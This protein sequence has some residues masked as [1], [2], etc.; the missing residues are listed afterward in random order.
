MPYAYL[1]AGI[2][3]HCPVLIQHGEEAP[4][5]ECYAHIHRFENSQWVGK[6]LAEVQR[7]VE[8]QDSYS[9]FR[10]FFL[11]PGTTY[12]EEFRNVGDE[13][14][15]LGEGSF[16]WLVRIRP[17]HLEYWCRDDCY[18]EPYLPAASPGNLVITNYMLATLILGSGIREV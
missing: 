16:K 17:S 1:M 15:M 5:G 7:L 18:L 9:L 11:I 4:E 13:H 14:T 2:A 8:R 10:Y 6:Y 12:G 3:L